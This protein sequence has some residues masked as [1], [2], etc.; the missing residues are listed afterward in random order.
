M[1]EK[2]FKFDFSKQDDQQ[3]FDASSQEIKDEVLKEAQ[4][5]AQN[6]ND[7]MKREGLKDPEEAMEKI[8]AKMRTSLSRGSVDEALEIK[9]NFP[10][11]P[12]QLAL[13]EVEQAALEGLKD[14][15]ANGSVDGALKIK[16]NFPIALEK[17]E[18]AAFEGLRDR[19]ARGY[20]D[21]A[22]KIKNNFP[23]AHEKLEQ[24]VFEGLRDYLSNEYN[25][26]ATIKN[27]LSFINKQSLVD[28]FPEIAVKKEQLME[29]LSSQM[30]VAPEKVKVFSRVA[31]RSL[32]AQVF[33]YQN[34]IDTLV[35][36]IT[37]SPFLLDAVIN[38][39]MFGTR[40]FAAYPKF[41]E[42][43]KEKITFLFQMKEEIMAQNPR[44]KEDTVEFRWAMQEKLKTYAKNPKI[45]QQLQEAGIDVEN[46]LNYDVEEEFVLGGEALE[47]VSMLQF[48]ER[49]F[50]R[51]VGETVP[52]YIE[53]VN[54]ELGPYKEE[55]GKIGVKDEKMI[56]EAQEKITNRKNILAKTADEKKRAG[57]E[58]GIAS[59]EKSIANAK[60]V[61][62]AEKLQGAISGIE[63]I[64]N[65]AKKKK[66]EI[67]QA[68]QAK[69]Y[70][71]VNELKK[72]LH[73]DYKT[74]CQRFNSF[75]ED[76]QNYMEK[77]F[78]KHGQAIMQSV[79]SQVTE[80]LNHFATDREDLEKVFENVD[81][82]KQIKKPKAVSL[83]LWH[84]NPDIDL[85][86]GNYSPCCISIE[87]GSGGNN[88]ES[89]LADYLTDVAMQVLNLTDKEKNVPI[90]SAWLYLGKNLQ[91]EAA[92]I[93]DNIESDALQTNLYQDEIWQRVQKYILDYA[94]K[95][96]VKKVSMGRDNNDIE[97]K[98][99]KTDEEEYKKIGP[100]NGKR[101]NGYYLESE[102]EY[103]LYM[104][105]QK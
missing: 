48:I 78:D 10:I 64:V 2:V 53:I 81:F 28:A 11:A 97:P 63:N 4:E 71:K 69:K 20:I 82:D 55:L 92:L 58:K 72:K 37:Q 57:I 21:E 23:I 59:L 16:N 7:F 60:T 25:D 90:M 13:P 43:S 84:R 101:P 105:W 3:K 91:G 38:N 61:P 6:L 75:Q 88:S 87:S 86:L 77:Y 65:S 34:N 40:L 12:E 54:E 93:I 36:S 31:D 15:L 45:L 79:N 94:N 67:K 74:L 49:P 42:T 35:T 18:Q 5:K 76:L 27:Y 99:A 47:K 83:G 96:G 39:E 51:I 73:K 66:E 41:D 22:L 24:A 26:I 100:V 52:K 14:R 56:Q 33:L 85:Y 32:A 30:N 19:L 89:A 95:I 102:E 44:I 9:N 17:L 104:I 1:P 70:Q 8:L 68:E 50:N 29:Y 62:L 46:W 103:N 80:M 98:N